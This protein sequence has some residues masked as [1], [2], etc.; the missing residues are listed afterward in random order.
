MPLDQADVLVIG[1][2]FSMYYAWQSPLVG[3]GYR[4]ASAHWD[5]IGPLCDDFASWL[6]REG[7]K[8][9]LVLIESIERLLP[10]RLDA[11][12]RLPQPCTAASC[13][14]GAGREPRRSRLPASR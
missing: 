3:A 9:K 14:A 10:E 7:F 11:G 4:I 1:D 12:A 6:R 2:S 13:H 5:K 8:G